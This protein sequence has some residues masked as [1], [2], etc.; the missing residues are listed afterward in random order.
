MKLYSNEVG[1][2]ALGGLYEVGK[3]CYG[4][5]YKDE[6]ILIDCGSLFPDD[7][8]H[9]V[10]QILPNFDYLRENQD[11]IVGIFI[12][13]G[14]EDHIGGI[15]HLSKNIDIKNIY[16]SGLAK[17]LI[18]KKI[19]NKRT[20]QLIRE[21]SE[22]DVINTK[23]FSV[24]FY[25]TNHSIPDSYGIVVKTPYGNIV[26]SGDYKFD[27]TPIGPITNFSKITKTA[28]E[29]VLCLLS[30]STNSLLPGFTLSE[31]KVGDSI[32]NIYQNIDGRVIVASFASN[33]H[34]IK[35]IVESSI[36]TKRKVAIFGR[37]MENS[38][39]VGTELG[40][41]KAPRGTFVN[42]HHIK[43]LKNNEVT[44]LCT[45]SQG[46][47]LAALSRIANGT[48]K[49]IK[50]IPGDTVIFSSSPIPGN[51]YSVNRTINNLFKQGA[52]VIVNSPL[53]DTHT[54]GHAG[55]GEQQLLFSLLKPKHFIPI[56]GEYHM[57]YEHVETAIEC[58]IKPDNCH[59]IENGEVLGFTKTKVR[60]VGKINADSVYISGSN[61]SDISNAIL[62]QRKLLSENGILTIIVSMNKKTKEIISTPTVTSRGF[63]F[64][65]ENEELTDRIK[66]LAVETIEGY[67]ST[68][69]HI[70]ADNLRKALFEPIRNLIY[71]ITERRPIVIPVIMCI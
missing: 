45:G 29:G 44:I 15:N 20:Q 5:Q 31:S 64:M 6:I 65:K 26:H 17:G 28:E 56:H 14:H 62:R 46:E 11:K 23:H 34:R 37:S 41:I 49:D 61:V 66:S 2:F 12:T 30:D 57:L 25:R 67:I 51:K 19:G 38:I 33:I 4:I 9:G 42:G 13:H 3:N 63:I 59:I 1:V 69:N 32:N 50:I 36:K 40:Y 35:Q 8:M 48:H 43:D 60:R 53:T 24:S 18:A 52:N 21:Y 68:H 10:S 39:K 71:E 22:D 55:Q 58:G 27:F 7:G 16:T 54:S 70:V 47:P